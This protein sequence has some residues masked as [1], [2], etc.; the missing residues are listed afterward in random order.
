MVY[1]FPFNNPMELQNKFNQF[2]QD[3]RSQWN[4]DPK[5]KVEQ[6]LDSGKMTQEQYDRF[7]KIANEFLGTNY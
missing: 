6:L 4:Q 3:Y 7:R 5:E 2:V 1:R